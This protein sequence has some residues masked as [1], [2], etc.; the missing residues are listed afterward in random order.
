MQYFTYVVKSVSDLSLL[1]LFQRKPGSTTRIIT[2]N[3]FR[4]GQKE[5]HEVL[6]MQIFDVRGK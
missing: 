3:S 1:V 2:T 5:K 6:I 4:R